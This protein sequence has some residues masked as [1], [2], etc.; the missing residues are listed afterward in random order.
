MKKKRAYNADLL[1][2]YVDRL[3]HMER[4]YTALNHAISDLSISL[5]TLLDDAK[6]GEEMKEMVVKTEAIQNVRAEEE[7]EKATEKLTAELAHALAEEEAADL[8]KKLQPKSA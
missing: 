6:K 1:A 2:T 3:E 8:L 4:S 7:E 5:H